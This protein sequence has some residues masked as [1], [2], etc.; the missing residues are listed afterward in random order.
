MAGWHEGID[1]PDAATV[2][3][4]DDDHTLLYRVYIKKPSLESNR[5]TSSF[6]ESSLSVRA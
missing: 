4:E 6:Q 3:A 1:G 5:R 2:L